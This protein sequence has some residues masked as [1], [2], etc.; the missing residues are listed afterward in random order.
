MLARLLGAELPLQNEIY[1]YMLDIYNE[2]V[3]QSKQLGTFDQGVLG[4][5]CSLEEFLS[6]DRRAPG[7]IFLFHFFVILEIGKRTSHLISSKKFKVQQTKVYLVK[8]KADQGVSFPEVM[9]MQKK[10]E[11][12]KFYAV[13]CRGFTYIYAL[14]KFFSN[15]KYFRVYPCRVSDE[16]ASPY[17]KGDGFVEVSK[18]RARRIWNEIFRAGD[19]CFHKYVTYLIKI[20]F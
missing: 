19:K 18:H 12:S 1:N 17:R 8:L 15:G 3:Q 13:E 7:F 20:T 9:E 5:L 6:V 2:V 4:K 11:F 10:A 14:I 16:D